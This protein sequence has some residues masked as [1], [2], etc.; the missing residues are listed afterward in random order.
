MELWRKH[1]AYIPKRF[2]VIGVIRVIM[3]MITYD[4]LDQFDPR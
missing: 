3:A 1:Y 2:V 4:L